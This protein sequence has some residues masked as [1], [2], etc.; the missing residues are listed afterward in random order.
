MRGLHQKESFE[1]MG[2]IS[3]QTQFPET[4]SRDHTRME[5]QYPPD[6]SHAGREETPQKQS[7]LD[8]ETE[9]RDR[10]LLV[11]SPVEELTV[12]ERLCNQLSLWQR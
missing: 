6:A 1:G 9:D 4:A 10:S 2:D 5:S 11:W 3:Q 8:L 7:L 12:S